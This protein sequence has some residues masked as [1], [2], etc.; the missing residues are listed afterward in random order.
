MLKEQKPKMVEELVNLIE[1]HSVVGVLNMH[2]MPSN[3]LQTMRESLR[4][5]AVIKMT[6][7]TLILKALEKSTKANIKELNDKLKDSPALLLSNENPFRLFKIL[8]QNKTPAP[9]KPGDVAPRDIL[10]QKGPTSLPP[11]PSISTLQKIGLK[12]SVQGGK[13]AVMADKVVVK[14]G[15]KISSDVVDVLSL[16]KVEPMEVGLDLPYVWEDGT[17]YDKSVLDVSTE[18]YI[19]QITECVQKAVNLSVNAGY[20]TKLTIPIM[21]QKAFSEARSICVEA[22]ITE[23]DFIDDVLAK[24]VNEAKALKNKVNV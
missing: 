23:K 19:S 15:E 24:A 16:L 12:A 2:K 3:A 7:K 5:I 22:N 8:K 18:E 13:I 10:I 6:R 20:P 14:E 4:G 17:I 1:S 21:I 9:A 11:G